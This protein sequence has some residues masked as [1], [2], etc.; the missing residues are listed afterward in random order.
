M[1]LLSV[2]SLLDCRAPPALSSLSLLL[3]A[4][5]IRM[6]SLQLAGNPSGSG[7]SVLSHGKVD[8]TFS[9]IAFRRRSGLHS[10]QQRNVQVRPRPHFVGLESIAAELPG[11]GDGRGMSLLRSQ[12]WEG[13]EA[14]ITLARRQLHQRNS[15]TCVRQEIGA[16][17]VS[18]LWHGWISA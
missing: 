9:C 3:T 18:V 11:Q 7:P 13:V 15:C 12:I 5:G 16:V 14:A 6:G 1:S 17:P 10:S 4:R 2:G 8:I